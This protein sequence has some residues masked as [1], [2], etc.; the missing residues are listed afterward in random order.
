MS[1]TDVSPALA[2][3]ANLSESSP[4][5]IGDKPESPSPAEVE[6]FLN[7]LARIATRI[8]VED[9]AAETYNQAS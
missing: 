4:E 8:L 6:G 3:Q 9:I 7:L 1:D 5:F 2:H